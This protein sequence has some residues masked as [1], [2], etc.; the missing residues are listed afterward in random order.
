MHED[1]AVLG[2]DLNDKDFSAMLLRSLPWSY[3]SYL[4]AVAT[5]LSA[6]GTKL[7]PDALMLLIINEFKCCTLKTC[8]SKDK[9]V[10]FH[11]QETMK[12][13]EGIEE[14]C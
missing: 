10:A 2:N 7:T 5:A 8:Q 1:L 12:R 9:D 3:N 13:W 14:E 6:L 4:S 11:V